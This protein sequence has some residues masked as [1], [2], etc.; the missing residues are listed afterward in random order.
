SASSTSS[1][2]L[3]IA[4]KQLMA[5]TSEDPGTFTNSSRP[6]AAVTL[7]IPPPSLAVPEGSFAATATATVVAEGSR[8]SEGTAGAVAAS[9]VAW[10]GEAPSETPPPAPET[11]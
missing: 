1:V 2:G 6:W 9:T 5:A 11:G 10:I 7:L 3:G 8:D 4:F